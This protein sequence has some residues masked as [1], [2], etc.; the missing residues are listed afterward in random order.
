MLAF[1]TALLSL[2]GQ[3]FDIFMSNRAAAAAAKKAYELDQAEFNAIV[4]L[5]LTRI[6]LEARQDSS[7]AGSVEDQIDQDLKKRDT[8]P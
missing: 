5:A 2:I 1:L 6:R 4:S 8:K 3:I 7:Q